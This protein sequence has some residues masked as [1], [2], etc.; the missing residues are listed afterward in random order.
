MNEV[1]RKA[2]GDTAWPFL[3]AVI[4]G[5][6]GGVKSDVKAGRA[7]EAKE[8]IHGLLVPWNALKFYGGYLVGLVLGII[9]PI[10]D[11]VKGAIGLVKFAVE[12]LEWLAKWSPI[13]VAVSPERQQKIAALTQK[14]GGL[15]V[16]LAEAIADFARDPKGSAQRFAAFLDEMMQLALGQARELGAK[17]AHSIFDFLQQPYYDMGE[18]IGKAIGTLIVQVLMLVFSDAI[19]NAV[20]EAAAM[21]GKAAEFVAGK[22]VEFFEWVKGFASKVIGAM[23][24]FAKTAAK[25]FGKL[26]DAVVDAFEAL[27]AIFSEGE[28]LDAGLQKAAAGVGEVSGGPKLSNVMESRMVSSTRTAPAKVSDLTPPKIHPSNV[29]KEVPTEVKPVAKPKP[30]KAPFDEP[31]TKGERGL[32]PE[33]LRQKHILEDL[34]GQQE[35]AYESSS[36]EIET[37]RGSKSTGK[38]GAGMK[39]KPRHHVFPQEYRSWFERRGFNGGTDIDKFTVKLEE[40]AHQAVHGGGNYRIGRVTRFEWNTRVMDELKAAEKAL[41]PGR[42]LNV[43]QIF[44]IVERLM[45]DYKIPRRYGPYGS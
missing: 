7:A 35:S 36:R 15:A 33:Q 20:T 1:G 41:G 45:K 2:F 27:K 40:S 29:P 13:G 21:L 16:Q 6:V 31:L 12:A 9:S 11:L 44:G 34:Q 5:F 38:A 32:T 17:A 25:L 19:A 28:A 22:A 4:E 37:T 18:S 24:S 23:R 26:L 3:K 43:K 30:T 42:R 8:H 14:F 10:T 39:A